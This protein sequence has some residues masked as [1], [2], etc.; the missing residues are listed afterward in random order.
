MKLSGKQGLGQSLSLI[1]KWDGGVCFL[2]NE[3]KTAR[4]EESKTEDGKSQKRH[5]E[6]SS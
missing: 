2:E 4:K 5:V 6:E 1:L 3:L